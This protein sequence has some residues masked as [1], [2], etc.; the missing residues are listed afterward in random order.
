MLES[1]IPDKLSPLVSRDEP[2]GLT[3][4]LWLVLHKMACRLEWYGLGYTAVRI[5]FEL[6]CKSTNVKTLNF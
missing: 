3:V 6:R 1:K 2:S 5:N 4:L